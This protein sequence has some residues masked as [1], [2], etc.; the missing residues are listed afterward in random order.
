MKC[1]P[2]LMKETHIEWVRAARGCILERGLIGPQEGHRFG[3][4]S[5]TL[6]RFGLQSAQR[7][8]C[9][10]R[11]TGYLHW[12]HDGGTRERPTSVFVMGRS[13]KK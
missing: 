10:R 6:G 1:G 12:L 8:F 2:Y 5:F 9:R 3:S 7:W 4:G 11:N 13:V